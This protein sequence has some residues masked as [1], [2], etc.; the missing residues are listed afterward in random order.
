[1]SAS[2]S[3]SGQAPETHL[4]D[5]SGGVTTGSD[6]HPLDVIAMTGV[7]LV[8]T[9]FQYRYLAST[10]DDEHVGVEQTQVE[11]G[12]LVGPDFF[13]GEYALPAYVSAVMDAQRDWGTLTTKSLQWGGE[14]FDFYAAMSNATGYISACRELTQY[15]D[16]L[17]CIA[18]NLGLSV[19][20][21]AALGNITEG[22]S[23]AGALSNLSLSI[24]GRAASFATTLNSISFSTSVSPLNV[25][26]VVNQP[27]GSADLPL[28][29]NVTA[30]TS[31]SAL[32]LQ[33]GTLNPEIPLVYLVIA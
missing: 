33:S 13:L 1:M 20:V 16:G 22:V 23:S 32:P 25:S 3:W 4:L 7:G 2:P 6:S 30:Q 31:L 5:T 19:I 8:A 17:S 10:C 26:G 11:V 21:S 15:N 9:N 29:T 24:L 18:S 27:G 28:T 12:S 14:G